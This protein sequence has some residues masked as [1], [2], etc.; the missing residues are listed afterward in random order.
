MNNKE[1]QGHTVSTRIDYFIFNK[2]NEEAKKDGLRQSE[3][4]RKILNSYFNKQK[5]V[6]E[7]DILLKSSIKSVQTLFKNEASKE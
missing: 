1:K 2:L 5:N 3:L 4:V 6:E 7:I